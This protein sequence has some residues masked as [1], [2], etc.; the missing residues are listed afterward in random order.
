MKR[1]SLVAC[2]SRRVPGV[3]A[4]VNMHSN[5]KIII[6]HERINEMLKIHSSRAQGINALA[7]HSRQG[8]HIRRNNLAM[9][10]QVLSVLVTCKAL[11]EGLN[12]PDA[13]VGIVLYCK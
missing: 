7:Y 5:D 9:F 4:I 11:D 3:I 2:A 1:A 8:P 12:V 13:S 10:R 6:F